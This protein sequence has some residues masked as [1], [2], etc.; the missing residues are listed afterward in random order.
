MTNKL[1]VTKYLVDMETTIE[2]PKQVYGKGSRNC[3]ACYSHNSL[4][5]KY[6]LN[7]CRK[8]FRDYS[9]VIGFKVYD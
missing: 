5:R 4:I 2:V 9:S 6:N 1:T 8:C 7:L 3:R